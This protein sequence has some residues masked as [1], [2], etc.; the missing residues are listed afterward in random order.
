WRRR[1]AADPKIV[2]ETMRLDGRDYTVVGIVPAS[3]RLDRARNTFFNDL[4][5]PIGQNDSALF[6]DRGTGN[7]T[8]G[9]GRLKRGVTLA[10]A[11]A[12]MDAIMRNLAAEYPNENSGTG[13]NVV[14]FKQDVAGE[15]RPTV[16]A[17]GVAVGF[18][19]LIAC[20]NVANLM[21]ARSIGRLQEI[22]VRISLG[23]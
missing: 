4:F 12:E 7:N 8:R 13:A 14:S 2:G 16:V 15:L 21:F 1:F 9:L 6:Y 3:V 20:T 19:L 11:R 22:S 17:L 23:A 10:Q 5:L 18:V